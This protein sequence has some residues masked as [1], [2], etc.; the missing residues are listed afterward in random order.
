MLRCKTVGLRPMKHDLVEDW[1]TIWDS[2]LAGMARDREL[3]DAAAPALAVWHAVLGVR[4]HDPAGTAGPDA[5]SRP[6]PPDAAPEP[7]NAEIARLSA[8]IDAL[9]RRIA[10]LE[11]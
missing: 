11:P 7:R 8:C 4:Q 2:E 5:A 3:L 9:E 1:R 10:K 6:T